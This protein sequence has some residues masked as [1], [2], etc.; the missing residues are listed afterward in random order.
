[1][2]G[3]TFSLPLTTAQRRCLIQ[4]LADATMNAE[5]TRNAGRRLAILAKLRDANPS[6]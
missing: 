3:R 4:L 5:S 1:M 2:T 6:I